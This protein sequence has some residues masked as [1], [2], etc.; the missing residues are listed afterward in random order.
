M[1]PLYSLLN[2]TCVLYTDIKRRGVVLVAGLF[3]KLLSSA[4]M[5]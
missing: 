3:D 2:A 4:E 1:L 5:G